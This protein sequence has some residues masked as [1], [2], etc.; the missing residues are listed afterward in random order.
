M[1]FCKCAE[2]LDYKDKWTSIRF[3]E[4]R[5]G[6]PHT[7]LPLTCVVVTINVGLAQAHPNDLEFWDVFIAV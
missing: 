7:Y 2:S 4:T 1:E 3:S 6:H 5:V